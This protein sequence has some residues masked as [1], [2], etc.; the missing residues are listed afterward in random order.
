MLSITSYTKMGL[1]VATLIGFLCSAISLLIALVY[2]ILKLCNWQ[3]FQAG[4]APMILGIFV[5]GS[6]QLFF[7]GLLGEY[8]LNI[9]TRVIHRP[10][11]VEEKR[12]NFEEEEDQKEPEKK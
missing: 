10:L 2:L 7:I 3:S 12:I 6:L 9:N 4:Y 1:R 11:V 8:I 5:L